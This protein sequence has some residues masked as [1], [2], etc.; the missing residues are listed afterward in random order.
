MRVHDLKP[1]PGSHKKRTRVGRGISAGQGKTAGR[2]TKGQGARTGGVKGP[3][4]EGGQLPLVRR[5][6]FK[7]G[8]NNIFRIDYQEVNIAKL[9]DTFK[10]G[11]V[12]PEALAKA[13]LIDDVEKPFVILGDGELKA[14]LTVSAHRVTKSAREKIE[15]AGGSIT[16]IPLLVKGARATVK[17]MRKEDLEKLRNNKK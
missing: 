4:F 14:K 5:L 2:G 1:D 8:F 17:K 10:K 3:Y 13:G 7:R 9:A 16:I 6:P 11:D 12:T 15:G